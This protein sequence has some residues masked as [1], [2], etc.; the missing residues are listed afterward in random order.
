MAGFRSPAERLAR[1]A[2][3]GTCILG[4]LF[5][6]A[7]IAAIVPLSFNAE[8]FF[9][10]PMPGVSLRWYA[11]IAGSGAWRRALVNS[12]LTGPAP[13]RWRPR[14]AGSRRSGRAASGRAGSRS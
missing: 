13:P 11:A 3:Y 7:P 6:L 12:L 14:S 8:G 4:L 2:L 10:Y 9:S 1:V 5:L